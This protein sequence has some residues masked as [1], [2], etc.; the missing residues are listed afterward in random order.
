M[1]TDNDLNIN[2][3]NYPPNGSTGSLQ[4]IAFGALGPMRL[5]VE[6]NDVDAETDIKLTVSNAA[7]HDELSAFPRDMAE[8][9][10]AIAESPVV[11]SGIDAALEAVSD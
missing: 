5:M 7:E 4:T 9:L 2:I 1:S 3:V 8:L 10:T 11:E 6:I